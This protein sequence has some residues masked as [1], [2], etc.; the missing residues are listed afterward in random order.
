[1]GKAFVK[2]W[3]NSDHSMAPS[4]L[5]PPVLTAVVLVTISALIPSAWSD[6]PISDQPTEPDSD[7]FLIDTKDPGMDYRLKFQQQIFP[8]IF[9]R[10]NGGGDYMVNGNGDYMVNGNGD[11]MVNGNGDYIVNGNRK[12]R[13]RRRRRGRR[14]KRN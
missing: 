10:K 3:D 5:S 11:Y 9:Q 14:N 8:R 12:R 7:W 1:M 13:R 6:H 4:F 2:L